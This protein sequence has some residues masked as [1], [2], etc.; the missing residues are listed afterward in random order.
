MGGWWLFFGGF[1]WWDVVEV[2]VFE[3]V[4]V[5]FEGDDFSMVDEVVDY[6]GS[7]DVVVVENFVLLVEGF[8]G[9]DD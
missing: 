8:I 2:V 9:C 3:L 1:G 4:V 7:N 5:V 6:G